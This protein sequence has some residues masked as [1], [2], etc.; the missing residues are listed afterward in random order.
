MRWGSSCAHSAESGR[1]ALALVFDNIVAV[2][3]SDDSFNVR[4]QDSRA[5]RIGLNY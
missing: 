1:V 2:A 5:G 4:A 3:I